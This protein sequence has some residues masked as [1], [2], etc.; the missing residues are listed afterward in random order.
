[1]YLILSHLEMKY[2]MYLVIP[3]KT[4]VT[5]YTARC[6]YLDFFVD[7]FDLNNMKQNFN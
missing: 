7:R 1:M 5:L 4:N 3:F 6:C 2:N